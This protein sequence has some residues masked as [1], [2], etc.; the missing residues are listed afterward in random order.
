MLPVPLFMRGVANAKYRLPQP[1]FVEIADRIMKKHRDFI[2]VNCPNADN[3][4]VGSAAG[5]GITDEESTT[6]YSIIIILYQHDALPANSGVAVV[7][8][9]AMPN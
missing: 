6:L 5:C 1:D 8:P 3:L 9:T 4:A 2:A 7:E